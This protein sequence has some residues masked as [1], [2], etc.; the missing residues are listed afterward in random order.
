MLYTKEQHSRFNTLVD[1]FSLSEIYKEANILKEINE[2]ADNVRD[3]AIDEP[4]YAADYKTEIVTFSDALNKLN[5]GEYERV[6]DL[7]NVVDDKLPLK[8]KI[9]A[10]AYLRMHDIAKYS[11]DITNSKKLLMQHSKH[12][13]IYS[14][15]CS[16]RNLEEAYVL[17]AVGLLA[18]DDR[19][20]WDEASKKLSS[21]SKMSQN[22]SIPY[23]DLAIYATKT[24]DFAKAISYL[25]EAKKRGD[26]QSVADVDFFNKDKDFDQLRE[27]AK[28]NDKVGT[29]L[30]R[31]LT[32]N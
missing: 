11:G 9:L 4:K 10:N 18:S 19:A 23:Y 20:D 1:G 30:K 8:H 17:L 15:T 21:A 27:E 28:H 16:Y 6:V 24:K 7:L 14:Q 12:A 25:D 2:I 5:N 13:T 31:I 3:I 32:V 22:D 26:F 29:D